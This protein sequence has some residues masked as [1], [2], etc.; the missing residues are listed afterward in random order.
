MTVLANS[1]TEQ[2]IADKLRD[3][4]K[5][6]AADAKLLASLPAQGPTYMRLRD[7]LGEAE[8]ACR[9]M[10]YWREDTRWLAMGLKMEEAHQRCRGWIV[11]HRARPIFLMFAEK[12]QDMTQ[13]VSVMETR[14]TGRAGLIMPGDTVH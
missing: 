3:S 11:S 4:L 10:A 9:M 14:K 6:A 2:E 8:T 1:L 7:R 5:G 13:M 12:L